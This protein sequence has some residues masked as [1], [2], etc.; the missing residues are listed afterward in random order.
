[1]VI[2]Y[3]AWGGAAVR[4]PLYYIDTHGRRYPYTRG[5]AKGGPWTDSE[6][7]HDLRPSI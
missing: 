3:N 6:I 7:E 5:Y 4:T 2:I 1:M